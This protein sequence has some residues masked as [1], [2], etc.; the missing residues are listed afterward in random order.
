M[1]NRVFEYILLC[2]LT[3]ASL[4]IFKESYKILF[5]EIPKVSYPVFKIEKIINREGYDVHF[6]LNTFSILNLSVLFFSGFIIGLSLF[7]VIKRVFK[8]DIEWTKVLKIES[9]VFLVVL[10]L[11][12]FIVTG[13]AV[14]AG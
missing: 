8:K 12:F 4:Y 14:S 7:T 2:L 9:A 11:V 3:L 13:V 10:V 6:V 5:Q 1:K